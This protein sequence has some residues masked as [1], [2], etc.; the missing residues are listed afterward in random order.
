MSI[1]NGDSYEAYIRGWEEGNE[2]CRKHILERY[3]PDA[4]EA[5]VQKLESENRRL[6]RRL[7]EAREGTEYERV[8]GVFYRLKETKPVYPGHERTPQWAKDV[9]E[10]VEAEAVAASHVH[11]EKCTEGE[12]FTCGF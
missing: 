6:K 1:L 9:Y 12:R 4:L 8:E 2:A 11:D 10:D 3:D 7:A 5:K